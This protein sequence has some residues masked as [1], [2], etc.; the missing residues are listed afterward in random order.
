MDKLTPQELEDY[1]DAFR[2]FDKD[3]DGSITVVELGE[4][5]RKLNMNPT[6]AELTDMVNEVDTD[7][8]GDIDLPEFISLMARKMMK[9]ADW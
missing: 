6:D 2:V 5:M 1:E 4:V 9:Q 3:D 8:N 7:G